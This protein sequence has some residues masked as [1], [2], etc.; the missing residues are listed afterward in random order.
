MIWLKSE[1]YFVTYVIS[2]APNFAPQD[3]SACAKTSTSAVVSWGWPSAQ[4]D[5]DGYVIY[6]NNGS[7]SDDVIVKVEGGY[8]SEYTLEGLEPGTTYTITLRA[9]QD[10]LG[11]ASEAVQVTTIPPG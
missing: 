5:A 1:I 3:Q 8:T 9:Y 6:Y 2:T 10:L 4:P 7:W 11:I